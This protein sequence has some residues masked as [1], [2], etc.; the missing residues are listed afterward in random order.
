LS[1]EKERELVETARRMLEGGKGLLAADESTGSMA[2][3]LQSIGL[4]NNEENRRLYRQV[5]FTGS[6]NL[7]R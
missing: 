5:L 4:E 7:P 6:K 1:A 2:K 3:R